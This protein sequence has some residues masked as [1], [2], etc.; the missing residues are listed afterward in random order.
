MKITTIIAKDDHFPDK[1][2]TIP[3]PPNK[4]FVLGN[5]KELLEQ[6]SLAVVGSRKVTPYGRG[7]TEDLIQAVASKGI[8]IISGLALGVDAIA[9]QAALAAGGKTIAVLPCGLDKPYPATNRQLARKILEQGGAL[10]SEYPDGTPPLQHHFIERNRLVSGLS[11]GLLVTEAAAKSG[12][13][14]T[15]GFALDQ[16]KTVM[17]VPGNITSEQSQGTNNLVKTGAT[18]ITSAQ[19]ILTALGIGGQLELTEVL[20]ANEQEAAI[21]D[22]LK[23]GI[24][25]GQEL[26]TL[27][28]LDAAT[29]NQTLTM[30][31]I[32][33]KIRPTGAGHWNL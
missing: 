15:A 4:L 24:T 6:P 33:G 9:H 3:Q 18:P 16:G 11:D 5:L 22:Q 27:S 8:V 30:L 25:D 23:Q 19:D 14:H 1:L 29:F 7:V 10:V 2:R 32:T 26:Q 13:I 20:P 21:L 12:T 28:G 31:E 17:A